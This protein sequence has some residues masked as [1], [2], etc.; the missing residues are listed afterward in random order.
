M[1]FCLELMKEGF[2][3]KG[4]RRSSEG[5]RKEPSL[6]QI[7]IKKDKGGKLNSNN[8][9]DFNLNRQWRNPS[10]KESKDDPYE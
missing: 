7:A 9:N 5:K 6:T 8:S 1:C 3:S 4:E 10:V 2:R